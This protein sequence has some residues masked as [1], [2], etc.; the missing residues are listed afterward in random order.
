[1]YVRPLPHVKQHRALLKLLHGDESDRHIR[2][3]I[4]QQLFD[5]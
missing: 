3:I 2:V 1:M 5:V 4:F